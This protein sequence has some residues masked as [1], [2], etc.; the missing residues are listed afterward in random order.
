MSAL[1]GQRRND[2]YKDLLQ[3]SNSNAGVDGTLRSVEDGEG[4]ASALSISSAKVAF[5]G[6]ALPIGS[7]SLNQVISYDGTTQLVWAAGGGAGVSDGDYGDITVS[8]SNTVW[9]IDNGAVTYAKIQ[10]VS[11]TDKIL[12]RSTAGAGVVEEI[13]CTSFG[14][15]LIDDAAASNARTTLGLVIGTDV[16]AYNSRLGIWAVAYDPS[17]VGTGSSIQ[18]Y[19]QSPGGSGTVTLVGP[20]TYTSA[21][22]IT[23]PDTTGTVALT[24][25]LPLTFKTIAVSGQSDVVA[26]STADTL[27][28]VAGTNITL[29]TSAGDDS[30]TIT[31]ASGGTPTVITVA[32]EATDTTCFPMFATAATG[33][34]GP[35]SNTS[36]T[37][38]SNTASLAC[39][40]FVGALTGNVTGNVTGSSGSCTGNSA[41]VTTNANLT[42][43]VTSS[44]NAAVIDKTAITNR[45]ADASPDAAADY[46]L[47]YDASAAALK[48]VLI[49]DLPSAGSGS[50]VKIGSSQTA[51]ASSEIVFTSLSTT[52]RDFV[53]MLS[54]VV[55]ATDTANLLFRTST[56]NGSTYDSGAG[57][58]RWSIMAALD[59]AALGATANASDTSIRLMSNCGTGTRESVS[60]WVRL[61][62]PQG[63][64]GCFISTSLS[65][66]NATPNYVT[67]TGGGIREA[68]AD[69]DAIRF[70]MSSGNI[71]S[72]VFTLYGVVA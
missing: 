40:T 53:I 47:T 44:G 16:Q 45:T 34:L 28:F 61:C 13:T 23:L 15:S 70:F 1:T 17:P 54:N 60:G 22:T 27:T 52:Y 63:T 25:D 11:A 57:N 39:T 2:T 59:S 67:I 56:D 51:S 37:F 50:Y 49:Q 31:A 46:V 48:K 33:D 7:P 65:G 12:G 38:N 68:S 35:K 72:G 21:K 19:P 10:N 66:K 26:D 18:F 24:S 62:N 14:R 55:P 64:G 5:N 29:T 32:N 58:Y 41:T 42:G 9:T 6:Y 36:L 69:V 71:A 3:V 43:E 8:G 20:T 4:T 30:V